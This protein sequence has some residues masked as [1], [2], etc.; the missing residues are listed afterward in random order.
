MKLRSILLIVLVS[1]TSSVAWS[2][3]AKAAY[4]PNGCLS[5]LSNKSTTVFKLTNFGK[6]PVILMRSM[7][8]DPGVSAGWSTKINSK[9]HLKLQL[10]HQSL[11]LCCSPKNQLKRKKCKS[12][13]RVEKLS[14]KYIKGRGSYWQV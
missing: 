1:T 3:K 8:M 12:T 4:G 6:N 2:A 13:I 14:K 11:V 10:D 5:F 9:A 7:K